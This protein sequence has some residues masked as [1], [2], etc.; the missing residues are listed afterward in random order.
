MSG[1]QV[2]KILTFY[3]EGN[4]D[5][6]VK[7][8]SSKKYFITPGF[9]PNTAVDKYTFHGSLIKEADETLRVIKDGDAVGEKGS[10]AAQICCIFR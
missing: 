9:R 8:D 6:R 7:L 5:L 2:Q 3:P 4:Y 1:L 10:V